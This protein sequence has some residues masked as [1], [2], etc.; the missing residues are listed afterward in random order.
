[1]KAGVRW[2]A[3]LVWGRELQPFLVAVEAKEKERA[4]RWRDARLSCL[5]YR[6]AAHVGEEFDRRGGVGRSAACAWLFDAT[7]AGARGKL[8]LAAQDGDIRDAAKE[9]ADEG[10]SI[11]NA[12]AGVGDCRF[13]TWKPKIIKGESG[14]RAVAFEWSPGVSVRTMGGAAAVGRVGGF[15]MGAALPMLEGLCRRWGVEPARVEY[16][17]DVMPAIKRMCC[18]RWWLRRL[19][20][21]HGRM[22][23]ISA[24][25]AGLVR[26]G[27]WAYSSQDCIERR[28]A[29]RRRNARAL[30]AA[31]IENRTTGDVIKLADIVAG[32]V[33]NPEIKRGELMVRIR[34]A[35]EF[36][37]AQGW[38]CEFWT[39]TAPSRFHAQ[40]ITGACAES[41]QNYGF[42][43]VVGEDGECKKIAVDCSPKAAQGYIS[44][45]WS[46][47]R[48]AWKRRGLIV[49]GLRTA[50]PHH[51]GC[52]HWHL[53]VY[54]PAR[55]LRFARRLLR[56][57]ALRDTPGEPG[58]L[59]HR[60]N[61]MKAKEGTYGAAYAAKYI[62][63][64][65][66]GAGLEGERDSETGAK[67]SSAVISVDAWA[68][69][70]GIRQFQF[71]GMPAV[72]IWRALR[73]I[74]G[75]FAVVG[76]ALEK[77]RAAADAADWCGFWKA[78]KLSA[79]ELIRRETNRMT[80]YGDAAA[81]VVVGVAEGARRVL[82]P[83][84]DWV[85][86]W[87]GMPKNSG[88]VVFDLPRSRVINCTGAEKNAYGVE[89]FEDA[90]AAVLCFGVG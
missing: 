85:I 25:K 21:S 5:P 51:D 12:A 66:N 43:S 60:F 39:V 7:E 24:I 87:G 83:V 20:R 55:D 50:E 32:S 59:R 26:R 15:G 86:H 71:F 2:H 89:M 46:R 29:Q 37:Q 69:Q 33:A 3:P 63:K 23:E 11:C 62:S 81:A 19:R 38:A 31:E 13:V 27:M 73:K 52:P 6:W 42:L 77:A 68:A 18:P 54:G 61:Y 65:I 58:A 28:Q 80:Q 70:W 82:L 22:C 48:A 17:D 57:Y 30:D 88:G 10:L 9:A 35:D 16:V 76:S 14:R 47:A 40:K 49:A 41:N 56:V 78:C 36:A 44:R 84:R 75:P 74:E 8:R 53:I 34:G 45:V 79:L 4:E 90:A 64:N 72:G 1:M 67:V